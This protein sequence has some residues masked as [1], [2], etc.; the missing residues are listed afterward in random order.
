MVH[1]VYASSSSCEGSLDLPEAHEG[2]QFTLFLER[3]PGG[4]FHTGATAGAQGNP[5]WLGSAVWTLPAADPAPSWCPTTVS[6]ATLTVAP[7]T[8]GQGDVPLL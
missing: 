8:T 5:R 2:P 7:C 4:D 1:A 3:V 6:Y